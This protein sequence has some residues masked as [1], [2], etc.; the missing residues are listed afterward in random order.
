[1]HAW[2]EIKITI[3]S[4]KLDFFSLEECEVGFLQE[5][6]LIESLKEKTTLN[7]IEWNLL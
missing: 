1:M 7:H 3:I 4:T 5:I 2:I 6:R